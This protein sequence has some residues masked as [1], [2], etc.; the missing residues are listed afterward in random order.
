MSVGDT[1]IPDAVKGISRRFR[2]A[3]GDPFINLSVLFYTEL[4]TKGKGSP[5]S[6]SSSLSSLAISSPSATLDFCSLNLA[7]KL[8]VRFSFFLFC[9]NEQVANSSMDS[10]KT[11]ATFPQR[12]EIIIP[13]NKTEAT[14]LETVASTCSSLGRVRVMA[15]VV[16]L[17]SVS[18]SVA[19]TVYNANLLSLLESEINNLQ[20]LLST[21][22]KNVKRGISNA[23]SCVGIRSVG[24]GTPDATLVDA[25]HG[26]GRGIFDAVLVWRRECLS[27][28]I[29]PDVVPDAVKNVHISFPDIFFTFSDIFVHRE[30][31]R[32][33]LII[34][35]YVVPYV[36][37]IL[38]MY[39]F[40]R[41]CVCHAFHITAFD[42]IPY[43]V[44]FPNM[45]RTSFL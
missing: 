2:S 18:S 14:H 4:K 16:K 34:V 33:F 37:H 1:L 30:Y 27:R 44:Q 45:K 8:R 39:W 21:S 20:P 6:V 9:S 15:L 19:S 7:V 32:L 5:P 38:C 25:C 41:F 11:L 17:F 12:M 40:L 23:A 43:E 3:S 13:S 10:I 42:D 24:R 26:V 36:Y 22:E 35:V 29:S 31:P 28:L